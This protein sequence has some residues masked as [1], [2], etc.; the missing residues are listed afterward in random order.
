MVPTHTDEGG[1]RQVSSGRRG[2]VR[3]D[4]DGWVGCTGGHGETTKEVS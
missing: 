4:G 2:E 3:S 1:T